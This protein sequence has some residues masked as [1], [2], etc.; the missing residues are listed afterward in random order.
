M[1]AIRSYYV[2]DNYCYNH[3]LRNYGHPS[4]FG[5]KDL[6]RLWKAE[7]F[8]PEK[9]MEKYYKAGARYVVAQAMHHDHFFNYYSN[10]NKI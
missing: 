4:E 8:N 1:Y 10:L 9:L 6:C 2:Q 7:N 5:Y 3:H